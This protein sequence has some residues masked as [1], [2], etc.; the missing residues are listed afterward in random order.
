MR[1]FDLTEGL[2]LLQ[3]KK[4]MVWEFLH[5]AEAV[6][7]GEWQSKKVQDPN[8]STMLELRDTSFV[9]HVPGGVLQL[10]ERAEPNLPW[11]EDHFLERVC[12]EP[13]NPPPSEVY[14]PFAQQS[15]AQ[16]K[17]AAEMFSHTYPERFWPKYAG[18]IQQSTLAQSWSSGALPVNRGIRYDY[19][20]LNDV[21][22]QLRK[23]P[24][25]RQAFLPVWFPED[26]GAVH[27]ERVPCTLGYLFNIRGQRLHCV[28]YIRSCD[29][30]R[31]FSDDVYMAARLMQWMVEQLDEGFK[32]GQL[33]M[34]MNSFH[35]FKGDIPRLQ[36][37]VGK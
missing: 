7:V 3:F 24:H 21:V 33:T 30:L 13:L 32:T 36:S 5:S 16:H 1:A 6:E 31:H 37:M 12:G 15:N 8:L 35:C 9:W 27:G 4:S 28:Y 10:Q 25:T 19:G 18:V 22:E 11:A 29:F 26:T 14:W 23:S 20:D 2:T 17:T 34:H